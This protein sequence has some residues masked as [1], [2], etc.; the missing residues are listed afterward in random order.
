MVS[1]VVEICYIAIQKSLIVSIFRRDVI[2]AA[3]GRSGGNM[4]GGENRG[5]NTQ[6]TANGVARRGG[7]SLTG[8]RVVAVLLVVLR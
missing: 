3:G 4:G 7:G 1:V 8:G 5:R 2:G 6:Y